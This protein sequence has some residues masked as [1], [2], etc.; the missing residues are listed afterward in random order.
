MQFLRPGAVPIGGPLGLKNRG[1][2]REIH[3]YQT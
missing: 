2:I 1:L 3:R